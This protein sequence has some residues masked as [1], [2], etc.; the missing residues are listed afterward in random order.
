M[1]NHSV[2]RRVKIVIHI[3]EIIIMFMKQFRHHV[4]LWLT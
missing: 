2:V 1:E 4:K 3:T